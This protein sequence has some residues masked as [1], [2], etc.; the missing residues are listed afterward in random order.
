VQGTLEEGLARVLR[1][2]VRLTVAGRTDAGVHATGQVAHADLPA[3]A[4]AAAAGLDRRPAAGAECSAGAAGVALVRRLAGVLTPDLR[5]WTVT[6]APPGFDARFSAL[7][8]RYAYRVTDVPAGAD[9][10]RRHDTLAWAR[11]LDLDALREAAA[12]LLGEHDFAAYCRRREG[13]TTVRTLQQLDW[14]RDGAGV[15]TATVRADAFCHSM[16]RSLVGALLAVGDGRRPP[17]WP[18]TLLDAAERS[19]GVTVA[20]AHGLTL[21]EVAYPPDAHLAARAATT[22]ARRGPSGT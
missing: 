20:P 8:R 3:A 17:G 12:G 16:V 18:A 13:A 2:P 6:P 21:V 7:W 15:L 14:T 4:W 1:A 10:L 11:P 9:P 22:R 19:G 5:V